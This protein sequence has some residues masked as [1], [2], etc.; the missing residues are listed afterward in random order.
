MKPGEDN[1]K[2]IV[3]VGNEIYPVSGYKGCAIGEFLIEHLLLTEFDS[4]KPN[5]KFMIFSRP[6]GEHPVFFQAH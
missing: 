6:L 1:L 3:R 4:Q 5:Y 2:V